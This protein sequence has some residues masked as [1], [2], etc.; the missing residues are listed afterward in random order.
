MLALLAAFGIHTVLVAAGLPAWSCPLRQTLGVPCPGCGLTRGMLAFLEGDW[1]R[2][3]T[4]HAFAP[5]FLLALLVVFVTAV[6]PASP[7]ERFIAILERIE[8]RTA[9]TALLL[10]ALVVYW[11]VRLLFFREAFYLIVFE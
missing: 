4:L 6:L 2:A 11:L 10:I 1:Q 3:L 9:I 8:R 5:L 7:K